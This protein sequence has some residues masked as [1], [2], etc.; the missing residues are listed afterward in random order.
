[1]FCVFSGDGVSRLRDYLNRLF[2]PYQEEAEA[3]MFDDGEELD[4]EEGQVTGLMHATAIHD[5]DDYIDIGSTPP[6]MVDR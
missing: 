2:S 5:E 3:T 1:M 4:E 6:P